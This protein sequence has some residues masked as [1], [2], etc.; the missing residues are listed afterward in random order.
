MTGAVTVLAALSAVAGLIGVGGRLVGASGRAGESPLEAW[1]APS[2]RDAHAPFAHSGVAIEW[3]VIAAAYAVG[4]GGWALAPRALWRYAPERLGGARAEV[5]ALRREHPRLVARRDLHP[6]RGRL[7]LGLEHLPR[8][9]RT[10]ASSTG[11]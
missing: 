3:G 5:P 4:A 7:H 6:H 9:V 2:F 11:S 10:A 1:L 8:R